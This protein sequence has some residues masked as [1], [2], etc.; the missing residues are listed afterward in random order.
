ML[1]PPINPTLRAG[2]LYTTLE[3]TLSSSSLPTPPS[4]A[5]PL[6]T[7]LE[8]MVS[9]ALYL[10]HPQ[11]GASLH[12]PRPWAGPLYTTLE[13]RLSSSSDPFR[14]SRVRASSRR[15][16]C[17]ADAD[18]RGAG[19]T[20]SQRTERATRGSPRHGVG[21]RGPTEQQTARSSL[22]LFSRDATLNGF[23]YVRVDLS[24]GL[25]RCWWRSQQALW[26]VWCLKPASPLS[27]KQLGFMEP[28]RRA[29]KLFPRTCCG[30]VEK[31]LREAANKM[32]K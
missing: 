21:A 32:R 18:P 28:T 26:C 5:G 1:R 15:T 22:R 27:H 11:G 3:A 4:G 25:A 23:F 29:H 30:A 13:A 8:A 20:T 16:T 31:P 9:S 12:H 19:A 6:Y 14:P 7:T 2:P 10:P 17:G 24:R